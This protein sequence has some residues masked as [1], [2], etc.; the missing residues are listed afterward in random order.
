[1]IAKHTI[2]AAPKMEEA[3]RIV[4]AALGEISEQDHVDGVSEAQ[5]LKITR[6]YF[7]VRRVLAEIDGEK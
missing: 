5:A 6:A 1:M 7:Q 3:L 2:A 4:E